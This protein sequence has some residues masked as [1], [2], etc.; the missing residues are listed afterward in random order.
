M[1][2]RIPETLTFK[3]AHVGSTHDKTDGFDGF[4]QQHW[5]RVYGVLL[6][7]VGDPAEADDLTLEVFWKLY[8][9]MRLPDWML[10]ENLEGWLYR[11]AVNLGYNALRSSSRRERYEQEAGQSLLSEKGASDPE[12]LVEQ[13]LERARVRQ[14]MASMK[15][16]SAQL[17][18]L[19]HSG[20]AY[21]EIASTMKLNPTSIGTLLAR[22][23]HEFEQCY[24]KI[25][26]EQVK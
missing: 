4:F 23:E 20:L 1:A 11:V 10:P 2:Q 21:A 18:L 17:L 15:A 14:V 9:R 13:E 24:R 12:I 25:Q 16:R 19:R 26:T 3:K 7:L 6:R 22:A 8:R 5:E